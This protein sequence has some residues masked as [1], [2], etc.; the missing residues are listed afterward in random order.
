MTDTSRHTDD[1]LTAIRGEL[2]GF[3]GD[4]GSSDRDDCPML[5]HHR[6]GVVLLRGRK[7]LE[8]G[9]AERLIPQL[10]SACTVVDRR[11]CLVMPGFID[12]HVHYPQLDVIASPGRN[13]LDWLDRYTFPAERRFADPDYARRAAED[14]LDELLTH[15]TTSALVF[16]TVHRQSVDAFFAAAQ[17]RRMRMIA[18]KVMMDRNCPEDLRDTPERGARETVELIERW[19]GVDRLGYAITPRFAITSS[20]DQLS[21]AGELARRYPD[22]WVH[23]HVAE[24]KEEVDW[25]MKLFPAAR[26]YLDVYEQSGLLRERSVWAHCLWLDRED[27]LRLAA[28]G[29]V[30]AFCPS[31]NLFL[32]SGLFDLA[33]ADHAEMRFGVAT[34]VG[35]GSSFSMLRTLSEAWKVAQLQGQYLSPLRAFY[36]ATRG[37][38]TALGLD[39]RIGSLEAGLE[40]D[41]VIL[42]PAATALAERRDRAGRS[43]AERLFVLM[44]L[45][46]D[47]SIIETWVD[48]RRWAGRCPQAARPSHS[49]R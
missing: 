48:G 46:D 40:A 1:S 15:G 3:R 37:G 27:R 49:P 14:F 12:L 43:L 6:D 7:I 45:G 25:V 38:A 30:A 41:L 2:V 47:R 31:S 29:G 13:L 23:S 34:D 36:L 39:H 8:V 42:D 35:G 9:D 22:T 5:H 28:R 21:V 32:G 10:D 33:A 44:M 24:N 18:G 17:A 26:S 20:P 4:P 11:G 16:G 19:Q